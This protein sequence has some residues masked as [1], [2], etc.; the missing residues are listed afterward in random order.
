MDLAYWLFPISFALTLLSMPL[1]IL[2]A[3]HLRLMDNPGG[4]KQHQRVTPLVGGMA[5]AVGLLPVLACMHVQ[6][7]QPLMW[8]LGMLTMLALGVLDDRSE[9]K[10][11]DRFLLHITIGLLLFGADRELVSLGDLIGFGPLVLGWLA[12]PVTLFSVAAAINSMNM[13]DGVDGLL[14]TLSAI[15][16]GAVMFISWQAG[17][18]FEFALSGC[19]FISIL[20]FLLFNFRFPWTRHARVFMGDAG[21]T[22]IGFSLAWLLISEARLGAMPPVLALYLLALPLMDTAGVICRRYMAGLSAS[23]PGRDHLHH[24]L[25]DAGLSE[26]MTVV[27]LGAA[28]LLI[29]VM[30]LFL[31]YHGVDDYY[32][33]LGFI[34]MLGCY[35]GMSTSASAVAS[36]LRRYIMSDESAASAFYENR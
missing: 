19:L 28:S 32:L 22:L 11:S 21:S 7:L 26:A 34:F 27:T 15:P 36:R 3:P 8:L 18:V 6:T 5:I 1:L 23:T 33:F 24:I 31:H 25:L 16:L 4:R 35:I 13:V 14:G 10:A 29:T 2:A 9:L 17:Q 20:V 30:G 12:L